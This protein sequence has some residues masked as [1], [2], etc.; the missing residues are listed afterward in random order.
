VNAT[1]NLTDNLTL[2]NLLKND[3]TYAADYNLKLL[4]GLILADGKVNNIGKLIAN[5]IVLLGLRKQGATQGLCDEYA[6]MFNDNMTLNLTASDSDLGYIKM[7]PVFSEK[8]NK[9]VP[10]LLLYSPLFG[11]EPV[12]ITTMLNNFGISI[13]DILGS[14]G[15][16]DEE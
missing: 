6:T 15:G 16:D 10:T 14:L 9:Y 1:T 8:K 2:P 13:D 4:N 7:A 11:E 5:S 3:V 12:D